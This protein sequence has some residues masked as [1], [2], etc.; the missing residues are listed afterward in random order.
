MTA[1]LIYGA[2]KRAYWPPAR[3]PMVCLLLFIWPGRT[4][5]QEPA[6]SLDQ[7][8]L[9]L[10]TG[11]KVA[12]FDQS[13]NK[14]TGRM[15]RF[16]SYEFELKVGEKVQTFAQKDIRRITRDKPDSPL[17]GFLI[18]AAIGFGVTLPL[19]LAIADC[20][21]TGLAFASSG[22]WALS[23][24]GI[25]ALVDAFVYKKQVVYA[26]PRSSVAWSIGP[27]YSKPQDSK[28][29]RFALKF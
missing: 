5:A 8:N 10:K 1:K 28:G 7:L 23:G 18:G 2:I 20:D 17:N 24:G 19:N 12:V 25:G 9:I 14:T 21:E 22:I 6:T 13:G 16:T 11:D 3:L 29:V 27:V 4:Q 26:R 15:N